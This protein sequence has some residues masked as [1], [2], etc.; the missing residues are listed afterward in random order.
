MI[1]REST[2]FYLEYISEDGDRVLMCARSSAAD[3]WRLIATYEGKSPHWPKSGCYVVKVTRRLMPR[4]VP[5]PA[6][7]RGA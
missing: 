1:L 6:K 2:T 7:G 4:R 5:K 3:C